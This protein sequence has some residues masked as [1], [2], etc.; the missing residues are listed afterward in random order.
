M[1]STN[2]HVASAPSLKRLAIASCAGTAIEYYDFLAY[3]IAAATVFNVVFFPTADPLTG[4]LLALATFG[5]GFIVRPLGGIV[6]GHFGDRLGRKKMLVLTLLLMGSGTVLIGLLPTYAQIGI[7][8]PILLIILRLIQGFAA[9]GE[10]AGAALI[11]IEH[12]PPGRKGFYGSWTILGVSAGALLATAAF[13]LLGRLDSDQFLSWGW[14]LPFLASILIGAVGLLV[15][16][17]IEETPEFL[18]AQEADKATAK[19]K[20]LPFLQVIRDHPREIILSA[21]TLIGYSTFV[22]VVFTF[23][24]TYGTKEVGLSRSLLLNASMVGLAIQIVCIPAW[25]ALSDRI[26]RKPVMLIG[27]LSL[28]FFSFALFPL[29]RSENTTVIFLTLILGYNGAAAI[30]APMAAFFAELFGTGVRYS[31]ISLGYQIGNVLGG[32]LAPVIAT[33]LFAMNKTTMPVSLYLA[34]AAV[35]SLVCLL[36]LPNTGRRKDELAA[37]TAANEAVALPK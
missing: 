11:A 27:G 21:G 14:R 33:A 5:T 12:A 9:G 22:Y 1:A 24:L 13:A 35:V 10:F 17:G 3:A 29:I 31:G 36:S 28:L 34:A 6:I 2:T 19:P 30:H 18:E 25:A 15:R 32:G 23:L 16:F 20:K 37:A 7:W 4:T 8:A 26:G